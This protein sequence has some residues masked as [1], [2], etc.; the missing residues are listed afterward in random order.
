MLLEERH[1]PVVEQIRRSHR[2]LAIIELGP[3]DCR[4]RTYPGRRNAPSPAVA[5]R[6]GKL[7]AGDAGLRSR[8]SN[9]NVMAPW[10]IPRR[11]FWGFCAEAS[12]HSTAP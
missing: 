12:L 2:R 7:L 9:S 8:S 1:R 10:S 5:V 3:S 11:C 4:H 6:L